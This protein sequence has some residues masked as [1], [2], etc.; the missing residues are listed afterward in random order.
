MIYGDSLTHAFNS[1]WT[2]RYRL[3]QSLKE[4][5]VSFDFVGPRNDVIEYTTLRYGSQGY[6]QPGFDRD[7]AALAGMRFMTGGYQLNSLA[8]TYRPNVIVGLI[9]FNDLLVGTSVADLERHWRQQI[10][11][12]RRYAR[13]VDIVLVQIPQTW[14]N[15]VTQYD[16]M[17]VRLAGE[18]NTAAERVVVTARANFDASSDVFDNAHFSSAGDLKVA[19]VVAQA[20]AKIGMGSGQLATTPDPPDDHTWAPVPTASVE[21]GTVTVSWPSVT[22]ASSENVHIRDDNTGTTEVKQYVK[23]TSLTFAGSA[24]HTYSVWLAPVRD[25]LPIGTASL[26]IRID[27]PAA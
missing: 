10:D 23:G 9:G 17:L 18:L 26:P 1:D 5:N 8:R 11:Q 22:Y 14:W 16:D 27:V 25:Y 4:S 24:G 3:W 2:W 15:N 7:H 13:G 21:S 6:R 19:A 20:L 12:A